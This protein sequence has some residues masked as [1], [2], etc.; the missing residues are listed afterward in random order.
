MRELGGRGSAS[1]LLLTALVGAACANHVRTVQHDEDRERIV[2]VEARYELDTRVDVL[3]SPR[4]ELAFS[5]EETLESR[6]E[7]TI[8]TVDEVT[9]YSA[10]HELYEVP[11][12]LVSVPLQLLGQLAD[13]LVLGALPNEVVNGY[14]YWTFAALNPLLNVESEAR[15]VRREVERSI[16]VAE[17]HRTVIRRPLADHPIELRLG[18]ADPVTVQTD[19]DG[20]AEVHLLDLA[21]ARSGARPRQLEMTVPDSELSGTFFLDRRL[22]LRL[23]QAGPSLAV[24]SDPDA[25]ADELARAVLTIDRLGFTR[26]SLQAEDLIHRRLF[27]DPEL[28]AAFRRSLRGAYAGSGP[29]PVSAQRRVEPIAVADDQ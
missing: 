12:G 19:A 25:S 3:R 15:V 13:V 27:D 2:A 23:S 6:V 11:L 17:P 28:L 4:V 26:Y 18:S 7:T 16:R 5:R 8:T 29:T 20:Q 24:I 10:V 22:T 21:P 14:S 1:A 9:P